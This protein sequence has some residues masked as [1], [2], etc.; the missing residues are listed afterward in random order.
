VLEVDGVALHFGGIEVLRGVSL[1][2]RN[3]ELFGLIG[4][5]GAGK[6]SLLNCISRFYRP[7]T[8]SIR[9][10]GVNVGRLRPNRVASLGL[11]RTFQAAHLSPDLTVVESCMVGWQRKASASFAEIALSLPRAR[12]DERRARSDAMAM[13]ERL[14]IAHV[15]HVRA[16]DLPFGLQKRVEIAR[17]LC[18]SP[19]L[20]LLDEPASGLNPAE[21]D[22]MAQLVIDVNQNAVTVLIVEHNM[23]FIMAT[24]QRICVLHHGQTLAV[25]TPQEVQAN[26]SVVDAYLG[27]RTA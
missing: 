14:A 25:G 24:C 17:A 12:A 7:Q 10:F 5:N 23:R 26:E 3:G 22:H 8:G 20:I 15:A 6:S 19:S 9:V 13:L 16:V 21:V 11:G 1:N 2:V 18:G 4:P 27:R